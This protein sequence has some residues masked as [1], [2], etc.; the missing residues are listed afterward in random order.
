M[1]HAQQG[2]EDQE[3]G[4]VAAHRGCK[5]CQQADASPNFCGWA[6]AARARGSQKAAGAPAQPNQRPVP[7]HHRRPQ[8]V[9][10]AYHMYRAE[11]LRV[12]EIER[13]DTMSS[14]ALEN[15]QRVFPYGVNFIFTMNV[16]FGQTLCKLKIFIVIL[17]L[18]FGDTLYFKASKNSG[19]LIPSLFSDKIKACKICKQCVNQKMT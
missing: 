14:N 15:L 9:L 5:R 6:G 13:L 1:G 8:L 18:S 17:G 4:K 2:N 12:P 3:K 7:A 10:H 19:T 16:N 11:A